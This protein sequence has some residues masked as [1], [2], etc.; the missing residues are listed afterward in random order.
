MLATYD[1]WYGQLAFSDFYNIG[2][3]GY[4]VDLYKRFSRQDIKT[5]GIIR[6]NAPICQFPFVSFPSAVCCVEIKKTLLTNGNSLLA[7]V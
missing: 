6:N 4:C 7:S 3:N 5:N 2:K 1:I